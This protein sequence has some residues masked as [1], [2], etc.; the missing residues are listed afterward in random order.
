MHPLMQ[1]FREQQLA[2][3]EALALASLVVERELAAVPAPA[4]V[5]R[6]SVLATGVAGG[7]VVAI[8][9]WLPQ[10]ARAAAGQGSEG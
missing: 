7:L 3:R 10:S 6:R 4:G 2:E 1:T 9:G 5:T 8:G